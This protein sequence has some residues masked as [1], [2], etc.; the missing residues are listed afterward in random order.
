MKSE[1]GRKTSTTRRAG[2]TL[3]GGLML[4]TLL[5]SLGVVEGRSTASRERRAVVAAQVERIAEAARTE[6]QAALPARTRK[7]DQEN[8]PSRLTGHSELDLQLD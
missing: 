4:A 7:S 3:L 1:N 8:G 2:A 5:F 6:T